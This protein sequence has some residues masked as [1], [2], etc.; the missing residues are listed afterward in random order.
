MEMMTGAKPQ[1][2]G[3]ISPQF[4]STPFLGKEGGRHGLGT[5]PPSDIL[6]YFPS[7]F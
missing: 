6:H 1:L 2:A 5:A 7:L 4:S 3:V